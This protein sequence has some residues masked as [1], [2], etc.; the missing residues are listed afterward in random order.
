MEVIPIQIRGDEDHDARSMDLDSNSEIVPNTPE[1]VT[2]QPRTP[3]LTGFTSD[4]SN[5]CEIP[6]QSNLISRPPILDDFISDYQHDDNTHEEE[7]EEK[8]N[9]HYSQPYHEQMDQQIQGQPDYVNDELHHSHQRSHLVSNGNSF[10]LDLNTHIN[11]N[12][13]MNNSCQLNG[14]ANLNHNHHVDSDSNSSFLH[15]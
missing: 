7:E 8:L 5:S 1:S 12:L 2:N 11:Y 6:L 10:N 4:N 3:E 13:N 9:H 14:T 15:P